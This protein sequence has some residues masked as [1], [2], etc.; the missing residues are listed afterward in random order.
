[1]PAIYPVLLPLQLIL[2]AE[3]LS[4]LKC[5]SNDDQ[6]LQIDENRKARYHC[7]NGKSDGTYS[8]ISPN[9]WYFD[10][11]VFRSGVLAGKR[12]VNQ[13]GGGKH[14]E[15]NY[16]GN[17]RLSGTVAYFWPFNDKTAQ[18][19]RF[20]N[21]HLIGTVAIYSGVGHK[22]EERPIRRGIANGQATA[23][24]SIRLP[25]KPD[26]KFSW[27]DGMLHGDKTFFDA[28][29]KTLK[30][31]SY[32][33]GRQISKDIPTTGIRV[34]A[35][36]D[37]TINT[38]HHAGWYR[39]D[40]LDLP[41]SLEP[42]VSSG[43][44]N[45]KYKP[46]FS[47]VYK[48]DVAIYRCVNGRP[49]GPVQIQAARQS[50][51]EFGMLKFIGEL[52]AGKLTGPYS[53]YRSG[54]V[55][56]RGV[57]LDGKRHGMIRFYR[58]GELI[59][60]RQYDAGRPG[61]LISYFNQGALEIF[62]AAM[63][64]RKRVKK[65]I[66]DLNNAVCDTPSVPWDVAKCMHLSRAAKDKAAAKKILSVG[67]DQKIGPACL[68]LGVLVDDEATREK[69]WRETCT[70]DSQICI[71]Y[72]KALVSLGRAD[73]VYDLLKAACQDQEDREDDGSRPECQ[74]IESYKAFKSLKKP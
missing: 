25:F 64:S 73:L 44:K 18:E 17:G 10:E 67:C 49:D 27:R 55:I 7:A 50:D 21:D 56:E 43:V 34:D 31:I 30:K 14:T 39:S 15:L 5:P 3:G 66:D 32:E 12:R 68:E 41:Q 63:G 8:V 51:R 40:Y 74:K 52:K 28:N 33:H 1:M 37:E 71:K 13:A 42:C 60:E 24:S 9:A 47:L 59:Y 45:L 36:P 35:L 38:G 22:E 62:N 58:N 57:Y 70:R 26:I 65:R 19:S 61:T 48:T 46:S 2:A 11:G 72:L 69:Y 6:V 54:A 23:S 16:R 4:E 53:I 29:K 20:R